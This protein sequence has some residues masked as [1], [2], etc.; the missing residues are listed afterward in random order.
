MAANP[1]KGAPAT[2]EAP[3]TIPQTTPAGIGYGHPEYQFVQAIMEMQKSLGQ[4]NASIQALEKSVEGTK[5]KVDDL[6]NW[7]NRIL[8]GTITVGVL[9]SVLVFLITKDYLSF[10]PQPQAPTSIQAPI[11]QTTPP[12]PPSPPDSKK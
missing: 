4:I 1:K 5:S 11:S 7:K 8:G 10:K 9:F 6:V 12:A 3:A 2:D